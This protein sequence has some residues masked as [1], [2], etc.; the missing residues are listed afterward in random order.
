MKPSVLDCPSLPRSVIWFQPPLSSKKPT[1][2]GWNFLKVGGMYRK[3]PSGFRAM[4]LAYSMS[5]VVGLPIVV[6][7]TDI[8]TGL[9]LLRTLTVAGSGNGLG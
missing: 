7:C 6:I 9:N 2:P 1:E 8:F 3:V 4:R 5:R